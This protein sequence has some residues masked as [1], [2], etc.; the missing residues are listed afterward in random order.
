MWSINQSLVCR[1]CA[2]LL[3]KSNGVCWKK[4]SIPLSQYL[5]MFFRGRAQEC[6]EGLFEAVKKNGI[7]A[8]KIL[9]ETAWYRCKIFTPQKN[10]SAL[11]GRYYQWC[12]CP[13]TS[14]QY[15]LRNVKLTVFFKNFAW[16][17]GRGLKT[18]NNLQL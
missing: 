18:S 12:V 14:Y 6:E 17:T 16:E 10:I 3:Y 5:L 15:N 4:T 11:S 7:R 2:D 1:L 8:V 9:I 13:R